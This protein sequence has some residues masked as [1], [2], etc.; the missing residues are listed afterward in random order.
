[1]VAVY[2]KIREP[3]IKTSENHLMPLSLRYIKELAASGIDWRGLHV[4]DVFSLVC[5]LRIDTAREYLR[6]QAQSRMENAGIKSISRAT[7]SD[8]DAL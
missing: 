2:Q 7:A 6:R 8:L 3:S 5:S 1:M 4:I